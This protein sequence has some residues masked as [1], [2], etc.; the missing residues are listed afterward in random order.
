MYTFTM[1]EFLVLSMLLGLISEEKTPEEAVKLA[2]PQVTSEEAIEI[3]RRVYRKLANL[4]EM[5]LIKGREENV[6]DSIILIIK[7][8]KKWSTNFDMY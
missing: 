7:V 5:K 8:K 4:I 2:M 6:F 1:S 3:G